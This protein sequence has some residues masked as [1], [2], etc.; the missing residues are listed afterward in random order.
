MKSPWLYAWLLF[1]ALTLPLAAQTPAPPSVSKTNTASTQGSS[2]KDGGVAV[3]DTH[4][5]YGEETPATLPYTQS[6]FYRTV[7]DTHLRLFMVKP[8][9]KGFWK[10]G[11]NNACLIVFSSTGWDKGTPKTALNWVYPFGKV[12]T[13]TKSGVVGI[14]PDF[15]TKGRFNGTPEDCI[16]DARAAVRWV[17]EHSY[18]LGIDP[19]KIVCLGVD[20]GGL[21][22][23]W[24]AFPQKGPGHDDPGPPD[25]LPRAIILVNPVIDTKRI[26]KKSFDGSAQRAK[27]VS[28]LDALPES[29]P[30]VLLFHGTEDK[31]SPYQD[32]QTLQDKIKANGGDVKLV[33]FNGMGWNYFSKAADPSGKAYG[34]TVK[35][36]A[37]FL[38]KV[39]VVKQVVSKTPGAKKGDSTDDDN[40]DDEEDEGDDGGGG[41]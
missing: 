20:A 10:R 23:A 19:N 36:I 14:L 29:M 13:P 22:A 6:F 40:I 30:P 32:A 41:E 28:L 5:K 26:A 1:P 38:K 37:A 27:S 18:E 33:T 7:G 12:P 3:S 25:K 16:S 4:K 17:Q 24:T 21:M 15:R 39:G 34:I 2:S 8:T 31:S 35:A 9:K 11:G